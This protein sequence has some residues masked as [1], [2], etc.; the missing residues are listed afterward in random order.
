M[1]RYVTPSSR[2]EIGEEVEDRG[3]HRDVERRGRL[4]ADDDARVAGERARDRDALLEA[5]GELHG[6]RAQERLVEA[7][8]RGELAQP[9]LALGRRSGPRASS[10]PGR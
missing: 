4:V 8:R 10:A 1:K 9:L 7:H 6:P 3:L 2:L 5:A